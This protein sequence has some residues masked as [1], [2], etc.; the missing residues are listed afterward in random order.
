MNKS[1]TPV[2]IA[3]IGALVTMIMIIT[4]IKNSSSKNE[5][6]VSDTTPKITIDN[7][8]QKLEKCLKKINIRTAD[9]I[10]GTV[11]YSDKGSAN[12]P[13]IETK[14]PLT[15]TGDGDVD[16]EIFSTSE[17]AGKN[18]NGWLNETAQQ[19]NEQR[20]R[21]SNGKIISVSVRSIPSGASSDY[22][23]NNVYLPQAYTPSNEL[24]GNLAIEQG[25]KLKLEAESLVANTAGIAISRT[26]ASTVATYRGKPF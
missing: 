26:A 23:S 21:L 15:V 6:P 18:N 8:E 1:K 22:I 9:K 12:L 7:P 25:A 4:V 10:K 17:K 13:N 3:V 19:F 16:I 24:F 11:D 14:Y 2:I 20:N 5:T